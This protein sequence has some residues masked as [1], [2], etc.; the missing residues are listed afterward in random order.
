MREIRTSGLTR[1]EAAGHPAPPLL[2]QHFFHTPN[3]QRLVSSKPR[4][5]TPARKRRIADLGSPA[6]GHWLLVIDCI[7]IGKEPFEEDICDSSTI[8][9]ATGASV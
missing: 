3:G 8:V 2:Y 7:Q 6:A 9:C 1:A 5:R 4:S